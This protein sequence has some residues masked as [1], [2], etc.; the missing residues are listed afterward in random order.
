MSGSIS[1]P[2]PGVARFSP[3]QRESQG[4]NIAGTTRGIGTPLPSTNPAEKA[5]PS[6]P[7]PVRPGWVKGAV[8]SWPPTQASEVG[9]PA[10]HTELE[11]KRA[12][13]CPASRDGIARASCGVNNGARMGV[14][15]A[16]G[17]GA[18]GGAS[19]GGPQKE[20]MKDLKGRVSSLRNLIDT[21]LQCKATEESAMRVAVTAAAATAAMI[22]RNRKSSPEETKLRHPERQMLSPSMLL[23]CSPNQ[24]NMAERTMSRSTDSQAT[25]PTVSD[26]RLRSPTLESRN[27][28]SRSVE[29]VTTQ[30]PILQPVMHRH[31]LSH[32]PPHSP[33]LHVRRMR[34]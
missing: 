12:A 32:S 16:G 18:Y 26:R 4:H 29:F 1:P 34:S 33:H 19:I 14:G 7:H 23:R 10:D 22:E 13:A 21:E 25:V 24:D 31:C 5:R 27:V 6:I 20:M 30:Q 15:G 11:A 9:G 17:S 3:G 2:M 28:E 8:V